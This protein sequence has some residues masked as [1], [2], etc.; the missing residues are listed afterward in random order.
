[1]RHIEQNTRIEMTTIT[2]IISIDIP[3]ELALFFGVVDD[4]D[5]GVVVE[6]ATNDHTHSNWIVQSPI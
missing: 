3:L 2:I 1:M 5:F 6:I 4:V